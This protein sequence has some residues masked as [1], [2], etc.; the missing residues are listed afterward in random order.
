MD[1]ELFPDFVEFTLRR[2]IARPEGSIP[3]TP[4]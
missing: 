3:A 4:A 1:R 2:G